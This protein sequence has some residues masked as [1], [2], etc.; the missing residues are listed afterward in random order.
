[1][2]KQAR[3]LR[4][5]NQPHTLR[6]PASDEAG[7]HRTHGVAQPQS[8]HPSRLPPLPPKSL[9]LPGKP[10]GGDAHDLLRVGDGGADHLRHAAVRFEDGK[11]AL[12]GGGVDH[13]AKADAHVEDLVHLAVVDL[14]VVLDE[15]EDG[16]RL[17]QPVDLVADRG[18]D[19]GEVE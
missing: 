12:G 14:G 13:V 2:W 4:Y 8:P 11:R 1:M 17:D 7:A 5:R 16:M 15:G 6:L 19:A 9:V 3:V 10:A 18:G